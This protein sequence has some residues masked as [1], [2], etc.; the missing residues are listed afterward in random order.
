LS[1]AWLFATIS[2][3]NHSEVRDLSHSLQVWQHLKSQF[4][5]ASLARALDLKCMLTNITMGTDQTMESYFHSIK[6]I[7]DAL[8]V[9]QTP[10]S[11]LELIQLTTIGLPTDYDSVVTTFSMLPTATLF[12]DLH[13]K[14]LFL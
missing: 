6:T 13:S 3:A 11:D 2:K 10:I 9:I 5:M 1:H 8:A 14:L 12:D 4:D 7:A